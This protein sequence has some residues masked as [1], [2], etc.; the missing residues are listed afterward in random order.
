MTSYSIH[1]RKVNLFL[2]PKSMLAFTSGAP[3]IFNTFLFLHLYSNVGDAMRAHTD[4]N[5]WI[6]L[7]SPISFRACRW[8]W[9]SGLEGWGGRPITT[10]LRWN[11]A[12]NI[13]V[14]IYVSMYVCIYIYLLIYTCMYVCMYVS[15]GKKFKMTTR[16]RFFPYASTYRLRIRRD[17]FRARLFARLRYFVCFVSQN[18][19]STS[20]T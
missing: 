13:Y 1:F 6:K 10:V 2:Y 14:F 19:C 8:C 15:E 5:I 16:L 7:S 3:S 18:Y 20:S 11:K 17:L 12:W 9:P 4:T